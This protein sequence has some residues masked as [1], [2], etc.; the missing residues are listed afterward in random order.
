MVAGKT[1]FDKARRLP[2]SE[3]QAYFHVQV[4]PKAVRV[5]GIINGAPPIAFDDSQ[6]D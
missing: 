5:V 6:R 1:W 2:A 4:C 3:I